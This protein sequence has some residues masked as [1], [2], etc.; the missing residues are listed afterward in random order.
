AGRRQ[1]EHLISVE[2]STAKSNIFVEVLAAI[3]HGQGLSVW[4]ARLFGLADTLT[5]SGQSAGPRKR[6][7]NVL[8]TD[9]A[10]ARAEVRARLADTVFAEALA[11][12]RTMTVEDVLAIPNP[13]LASGHPGTASPSLAH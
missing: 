2:A 4:A 8:A 1:F 13:P 7:T 9:L 6:V 3:L 11:Y 12:G 5:R 10:A